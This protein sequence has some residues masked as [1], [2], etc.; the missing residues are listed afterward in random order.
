MTVAY[1]A[2]AVLLSIALVGSGI[3]KLTRA[4]QVVTSLTGIG[5]PLGLFP[6]LATCEF[7]GA[8]GLLVGIW[9]PPLGIAAAIGV[10]LYFVGAVGAH[11]RRRDFGGLSAPVV[12]LLVA[13]AALV[14]R[15]LSR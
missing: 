10:V 11:L 13:A 2:V 9:W 12:L 4:E 8:A 15:L 14:L 5:V 7:A 1:V 3:A 6:F